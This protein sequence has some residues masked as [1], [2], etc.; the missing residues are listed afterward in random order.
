MGIKDYVKWNNKCE[1]L[2]DQGELRFLAYAM[3]TQIS[4]TPQINN[5]E[6]Q[7]RWINPGIKIHIRSCRK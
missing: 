5:T 2:L 4:H 3:R 6:S 1:N 7:T